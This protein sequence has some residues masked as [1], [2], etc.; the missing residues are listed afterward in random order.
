MNATQTMAD[1][2][3]N[4]ILEGADELAQLT[5]QLSDEELQRPV[6]GDGRSIIVVVHHVAS[7][8]PIEVELAGVLAAGDPIT[9]ATKEG[10]DQMNAEHARANNAVSRAA[11]LELLKR[12]S[13]AAADAVRKFTSSELNNANRVSLYGNAPLTCQFFIEDH[14]LRHSFHHL[15]KIRESLV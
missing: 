12:N 15:A 10:I 14:A 4:R 13:E 8:Y 9:A 2:L 3:A 7:V 6:K 1:Q 11:T 5:S